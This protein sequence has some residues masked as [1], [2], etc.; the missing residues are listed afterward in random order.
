MTSRPVSHDLRRGAAADLYALKHTA[1][2][3]VA[4]RSLGHNHKTAHQGVTDAYIGRLKGNSWGERADAMAKNPDDQFGIQLAIQPFKKRKV[5]TADIDKYLKTKQLPNED[6]NR[7]FATRALREV[8]FEQW[9][10]NQ[11]SILDSPTT[12]PKP[13]TP[14]PVSKVS[15]HATDKRHPLKDVTNIQ[16]STSSI[17][18]N[19]VA[20]NLTQ[21]IE[22]SST[23]AINPMFSI[24]NVLFGDQGPVDDLD[25]MC[26]QYMSSLE[27]D[28]ALDSS[29]L[30]TTAPID[31]FIE[32]FSTINLMIHTTP[33]DL[34]VHFETGNSR[35]AP[36][37]FMY[38]CRRGT[39]MRSFIIEAK[40][41]VHEVTCKGK[42]PETLDKEAGV[43]HHEELDAALFFSDEESFLIDGHDDPIDTSL[44]PVPNEF[45]WPKSWTDGFPKPCPHTDNCEVTTEYA[46]KPSLD[47]HLASYH[48]ETWPVDVPC[49]VPGCQLPRDHFF[50]SRREFMI[51]LGRYHLLGYAEAVEYASKIHHAVYMQQNP[52]GTGASFL[53][54]MCLFPGCNSR[55]EWKAYMNYCQHLRQVHKIEVKDYFLYAPTPD[56]VRLFRIVDTATIDVTTPVP[57]QFLPARCQYPGCTHTKVYD[58][59]DRLTKHLK[60]THHVDKSEAPIYFTGP[61]IAPFHPT[62]C[63]YPGC[64]SQ[65]RNLFVTEKSYK[66]HLRNQHNI[67]VENHSLFS[68]WYKTRYGTVGV[69]NE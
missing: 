14:A 54:T 16:Q 68:L 11:Q 1:S 53:P 33:G 10:E 50:S 20:S 56:T 39:C 42:S 25:A 41:N 38:F 13:T 18:D 63:L 5:L 52:P 26:H 44:H 30:L 49:N 67:K 51:H 9:K 12:I 45:K 19:N 60:V 24:D 43:S 59:R 23:T 36:S 15:L 48:N 34:P 62:M 3:D 31:Q 27:S 22:E 47:K 37:R 61:E 6:Q 58:V 64:D 21:E 4:R 32:Y 28:Y 65:Q 66:T 55:T 46:D 40:R 57:R 2:S 17:R 7:R 35:D 69:V 29:N 8:Q